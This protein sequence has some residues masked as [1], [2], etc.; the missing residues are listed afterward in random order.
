MSFG[1]LGQ[2]AVTAMSRGAKE[3][4]AMQNTGEGGVSPYHKTGGADIMWQ[5]GTGYFGARGEDGK[6][7][8]DVLAAEVESTSQ[9]LM[10]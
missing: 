9:I 7:S 2:K 4:N 3:A 10:Y 1:S 5:L 8:L 6:F